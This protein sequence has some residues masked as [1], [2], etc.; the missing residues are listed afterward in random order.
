[1]TNKEMLEL[2][3]FQSGKTKTHLAQACGLS[4]Q[5]FFNCLNNKAEFNTT[6]VKILCGELGISSLKEKEAIFFANLG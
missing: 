2:K 1:M 3:I 6:Q 4:Y 5:G